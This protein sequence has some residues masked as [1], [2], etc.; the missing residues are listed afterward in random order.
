MI[1]IRRSR[2]A[3]GCGF[4]VDFAPA[5]ADY[6]N[7]RNYCE[8]KLIINWTAFFLG[9]LQNIK[10][11]TIEV[12]E[13]LKKFHLFFSFTNNRWATWADFQL[14]DSLTERLIII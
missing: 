3:S 8:T 5:D 13:F 7:D 4:P 9:C 1:I 14:P 2:I 6:Y 11:I 12:A 10:G